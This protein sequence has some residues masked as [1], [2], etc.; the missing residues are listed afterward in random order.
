MT[1]REP[2]D[3][4]R[5]TTV[6]GRGPD[7]EVDRRVVISPGRVFLVATAAVLALILLATLYLG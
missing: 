4:D 5:D 2:I 1:E 3:Q 7:Q 6:S